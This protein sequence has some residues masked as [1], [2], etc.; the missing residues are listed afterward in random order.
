MASKRTG[1]TRRRNYGNGHGYFLDGQE[2]KGRGVTTL[3]GNG[4]PKNALQYWAAKEVATCAVDEQD[5]WQPLYQ[6]NRQAAWDY[7]K[8]APFRDRDAAA[9]RGTDVH[10]LAERLQNGE[11]VDV[12]PE[13]VAHVDSYLRF[14][15]EW[16]PEDEI[17]EGV[18]VN[19]TQVYMGTF[20][21]IATL[22]GFREACERARLQVIPDGDRILYDIK[23]SRSGV[24]PEVALQLAGYRYAEVYLTDPDGLCDETPMPEVDGCAVLH[25]RA[26]GYDLVPVDAGPAAFRAFLYAAQTATFIGTMKEPGWGSQLVG[27]SLRAPIASLPQ[28]ETADAA[29]S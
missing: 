10:R 13:L 7:L 17:I 2:I 18:V 9:R 5:I 20:D 27:Q 4:F 26:D 23:T 15:E 22:P 1:P 16:Q 12:P 19:R 11:E 14:R 25:V 29:S 6:R 8:E 3:L 21:S 24:Y 28:K